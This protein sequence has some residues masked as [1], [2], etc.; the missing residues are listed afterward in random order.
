MSIRLKLLLACFL[1]TA[2]PVLLGLFA[3]QTER[4][5]G[6]IAIGM[7]DEALM[8]VNFV[9]S[10]ETKFAALRERYRP[11]QALGEPAAEVSERQRLI[12]RARG[13]Q[14]PAHARGPD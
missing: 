12:A 3:I 8:S 9:R 7:Y 1:M 6:T 11:A 10:A 5:L 4:G 2:T 13:E 14:A